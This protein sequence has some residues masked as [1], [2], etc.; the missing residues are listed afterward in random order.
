MIFNLNT[1]RFRAKSN[2]ARRKTLK[3]HKNI[4]KSE[5]KSDGAGS[6]ITIK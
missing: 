5:G 3:K 1:E 2:T 6:R 4:K